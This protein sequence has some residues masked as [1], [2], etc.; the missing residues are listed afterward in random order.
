MTKANV[1]FNCLNKTEYRQSITERAP[2]YLG[3]GDLNKNAPFNTHFY[4]TKLPK[5]YRV[6]LNKLK[7]KGHYKSD[8]E[9]ARA[10]KEPWLSRCQK[11]F[12]DRQLLHS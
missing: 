5:K 11:K 1:G 9:H 3:E 2:E 8:I 4:L 7:K 12:T 6:S 10:A